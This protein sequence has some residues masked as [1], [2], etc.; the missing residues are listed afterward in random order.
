[1][2]AME[3]V[4]AGMDSATERIRPLNVDGGPS[5]TVPVS[6]VRTVG[7][8]AAMVPVAVGLV[9]VPDSV[10]VTFGAAA[11]TPPTYTGADTVP[12]IV[13]VARAS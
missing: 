1:M 11:V 2:A 7:R 12:S 4:A 9:T 6:D 3:P 8:L 10:P 5:V 13:L